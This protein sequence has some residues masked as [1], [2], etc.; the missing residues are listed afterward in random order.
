MSSQI[1]IGEKWRTFCERSYSLTFENVNI[2]KLDFEACYKLKV[3]TCY[4]KDIYREFHTSVI[5]VGKIILSYA[6]V[7]LVDMNILLC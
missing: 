6:L 2:P 5:H 3:I 4:W 1:F 7:T